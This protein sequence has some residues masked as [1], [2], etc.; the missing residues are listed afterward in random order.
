MVAAVA[1]ACVPLVPIVPPRCPSCGR[2]A[3]PYGG[4]ADQAGDGTDVCSD[5]VHAS[6]AEHG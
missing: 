5:C 3:V 6:F 2:C 1:V 4:P